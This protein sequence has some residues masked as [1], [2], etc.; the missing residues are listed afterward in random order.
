MT[1]FYNSRHLPTWER[2]YCWALIILGLLGGIV[3]TV[4]AVK[5]IVSTDFQMPCYLQEHSA[6]ETI[7]L[8]GH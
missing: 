5:N 2:V 1:V 6:N 7:V 4:T 3:A 8:S